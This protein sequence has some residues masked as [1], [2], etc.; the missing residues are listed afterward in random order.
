MSGFK[1][2][3]FCIVNLHASAAGVVVIVSIGVAVGITVGILMLIL[4]LV[5]QRRYFSPH[6][7]II[8]CRVTR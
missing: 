3:L 7:S 2:L 5:Y 4:V 1:S 8:H 6:L